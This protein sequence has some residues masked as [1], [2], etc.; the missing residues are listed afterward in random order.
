MKHL[1]LLFLL[2]LLA[3]HLNAQVGIGTASPLSTLDIRGSFS[4][5]YR[6]FSA[7]TSF[8]AN[9][10]TAVFTGSSVATATLPDATTIDGS[11]TFTLTTQYSSVTIQSDGT[12]WYI[13]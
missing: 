13:L 3:A 1:Y 4:A 9:D 11:T 6:S 5:M 12:S 7:A 2:T 8:T 10:Y